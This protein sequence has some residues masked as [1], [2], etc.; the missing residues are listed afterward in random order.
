MVT[1][2]MAMN[3]APNSVVDVTRGMDPVVRGGR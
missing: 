1:A 3:L 2:R